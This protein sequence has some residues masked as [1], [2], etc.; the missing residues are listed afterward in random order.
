[1]KVFDN[2]KN[3]NI[4]DRSKLSKKGS[5]AGRTAKSTEPAPFSQVFSLTRRNLDQDQIKQL[6][7]EIENL[8]DKLPQA[9]SL[10]LFNAYRQSVKQLLKMIL[11]H[12]FTISKTT[13]LN[14]SNLQ[15]KEYHTVQTVDLELDSLLKLV[16]E[17]EHNRFSIAAQVVKIKGLL[18]DIIR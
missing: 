6:M 12:T 13:S 4:K 16:H 7:S 3:K 11:P 1:M 17:R 9:P 8:G 2:F 5:T 10:K 14:S 15:M 18:L